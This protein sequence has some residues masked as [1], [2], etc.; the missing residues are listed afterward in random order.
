MRWLAAAALPIT[1]CV[2]HPPLADEP[3][4]KCSTA[5]LADLIGKAATVALANEA[6]ERAGAA[7]VRKVVVVD[8]LHD[9]AVTRADHALF[10]GVKDFIV[11]YGMDDA[12]RYRALPYIGQ[13]TS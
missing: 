4:G 2:P 12:G 1:A 9:D 6:R 10:P 8:K 13:V 3:K 11:G 7:T 5:G